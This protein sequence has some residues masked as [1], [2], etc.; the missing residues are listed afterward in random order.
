MSNGPAHK[1]LWKA[2]AIN[3]ALAAIG[4]ARIAPMIGAGVVLGYGLGNYDEPD[5]DIIGKTRSENE[6]LEIN[7]L[8][9]CAFFGYW[10]MY[11]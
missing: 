8:L 10:A 7:E 3:G 11:G 4:W 9:G 2:N 1:R 5:L 6:V